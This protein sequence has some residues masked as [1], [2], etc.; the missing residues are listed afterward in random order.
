[1]RQEKLHPH[2]TATIEE[3]GSQA[4]PVGVHPFRGRE[5]AIQVPGEQSLWGDESPARSTI[6]P[7]LFILT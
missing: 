1:L 3:K 4:E 7:G 5:M 2:S 6:A